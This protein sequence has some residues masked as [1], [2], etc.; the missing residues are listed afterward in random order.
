MNYEQESV[1]IGA[2]QSEEES[3][4]IAEKFLDKQIDVDTFLNKYLEKRIVSK[5]KNYTKS[6]RRKQMI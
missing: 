1:M 2:V 4:N 5:H 3:E 6:F